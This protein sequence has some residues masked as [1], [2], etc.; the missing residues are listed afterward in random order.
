MRSLACS[1]GVR[2]MAGESTFNGQVLSH[3]IVTQVG[4]GPARYDG[5]LAHDGVG[6]G[7]APGELE[8]LLDQEHGDAALL[9]ALDRVFELEDHV[10]LYRLGRLVLHE[11][12]R[13]G[14][15]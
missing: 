15:E 10:W 6:A 11:P 5:A 13:A 12:R 3:R 2:C 7:Q 4:G 14:H 9:D 8:V 1:R